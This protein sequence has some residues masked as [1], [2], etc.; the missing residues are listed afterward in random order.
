MD[1][2][3]LAVVTCVSAVFMALGMGV[4]AWASPSERSLRDWSLAGLLFL[5][6]GLL[7]FALGM[8]GGPIELP[9]G[10]ALVVGLANGCTVAGHVAVLSGVRRHLGER[11]CLHW[12]MAAALFVTA[13]HLL[14]SLRANVESRMLVILPVLAMV[15]LIAA[16]VLLRSPQY[17]LRSVLTPL[18]VLELFYALQLL[19]RWTLIAAGETGG[20]RWFGSDFVQ[21]SGRLAMFLF[22]D[23]ASLC[24]ALLVIRKQAEALRRNA[25]TDPMTGWLNRWSLARVMDHEFERARRTGSGFHLVTFDIDHFKSINDRH[26]HGLGDQAICHVTDQV[27]HELRGYDH[28]FRTGGEEFLICLPAEAPQVAAQVAE[29]L[30]RRIESMPLA[31]SGGPIAMTVSVGHSGRM[32]GDETWEA[33]L[34][35]A[36]QALLLAKQGGRNRVAAW[37]EAEPRVS[38]ALRPLRSTALD[39]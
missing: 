37:Q 36:D 26:G 8:K 29:R 20:S 18:V 16:F 22:I 21:A 12:A 1:I 24:C 35:R 13:L 2:Y 28:K 38:A 27:S 39:S 11:H 9:V 34:K 31:T 10:R 4:F 30:R 17:Q 7:A 5:A 25:E 15:N 6:N 19:A 3:T 14:P 23:V 33:V 32:P